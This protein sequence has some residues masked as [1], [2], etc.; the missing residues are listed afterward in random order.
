[1]F[2]ALGEYKH[3]T[4]L[5][6]RVFDLSA[7]RR[8]ANLIDGKLAEYILYPGFLRQINSFVKHLRNDFQ[9]MR[10]TCRF[11]SLVANRPAL[12]E[13]YR[14]LTIAA[15]WSGGQAEHVFRLD[16]LQDCIKRDSSDV[17]A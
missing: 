11:S 8:C 15:D 2:S 9:I 17:V 7:N 6:K 1:M 14:L 16:P 12:H 13:N 4:A 3:L 5:A 10:R